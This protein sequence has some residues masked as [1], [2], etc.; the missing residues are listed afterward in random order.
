MTILL[1]G[2]TGKTG[3]LIASRLR[4]SG[5]SVL[6]AC[7]SGKVPDPYKGVSFDWFDSATF[8]NPFKADSSIKAVYMIAPHS[9]DVLGVVKPF[10]ELAISRGVKRFVVLSSTQMARGGHW[11]GKIHEYLEDRGVEWAVLRPTWFMENFS[12][13]LADFINNDNSIPTSMRDG[14]IPFIAADDIA[15]AACSALTDEKSHNIDHI[16]VGPDAITMDEA[17]A[18]F[19]EVLGRKITHVRLTEEEGIE[20]WKTARSMDERFAR[21]MM[22]IEKITAEGSEYAKFKEES[23]GKVIGKIHLVDWVKENREVW[24]QK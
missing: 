10:V 15:E 8:D 14:R 17:A 1:I 11:V 7:R 23:R 12:T 6:L 13:L 24:V 20:F 18:I 21:A 16:I 3:L 19:S 4:S 22:A 9:E 5:H 2:G